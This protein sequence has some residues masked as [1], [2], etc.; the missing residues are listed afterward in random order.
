V[1][2]FVQVII[3]VKTEKD[4]CRYCKEVE[5]MDHTKEWKFSDEITANEVLIFLAIGAC[6]G[7][8]VMLV[9]IIIYLVGG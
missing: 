2:L 9:G 1:V 8:L 7:C 6:I 4:E 5:T 3:L